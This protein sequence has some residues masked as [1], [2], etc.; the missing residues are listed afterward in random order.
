[1]PFAGLGHAINMIALAAERGSGWAEQTRRG[2][3]RE[4]GRGSCGGIAIV[5]VLAQSP[6]ARRRVLIEGQRE[7]ASRGLCVRKN[8][9]SNRA[10]GPRVQITCLLDTDDTMMVLLALAGPEV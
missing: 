4:R 9:A 5:P 8:R 1:V 7:C 10:G 3:G 2:R 6:R